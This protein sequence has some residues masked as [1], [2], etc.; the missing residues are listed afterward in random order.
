MQILFDMQMIIHTFENFSLFAFFRCLGFPRD[1]GF[2]YASCEIS[3]FLFFV[4]EKD[5][6]YLSTCSEFFY[7][8][9]SS[10]H[11]LFCSLSTYLD[12]VVRD[13]EGERLAWVRGGHPSFIPVLVY[14]N[15]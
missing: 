9:L 6:V 1:H 3:R 10:S 4:C 2:F 13:V 11:L 12:A 7:F 8:V 15:F 5:L 14:G